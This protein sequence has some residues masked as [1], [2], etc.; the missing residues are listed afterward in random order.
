MTTTVKKDI[1][2]LTYRNNWMSHEY[3]ANGVLMNTKRLVS[4]T[5]CIV[6]IPRPLPVVIKKVVEEYQDMRNKCTA[7]SYQLYIET[8]D[9]VGYKHMIPLCKLLADNK[10]IEILESVFLS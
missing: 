9:D 8:T 3:Y 10:E 6:D 4:M 1:A 2:M 7:E 5:I